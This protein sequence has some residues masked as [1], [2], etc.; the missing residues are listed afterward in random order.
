ML[1]AATG[2]NCSTKAKLDFLVRKS[3]KILIAK[4]WTLWVEGSTYVVFL[5]RIRFP[6]P[7]FIGNTVRQRVLNSIGGQFS[8]SNNFPKRFFPNTFFPKN[9]VNSFLRN[10]C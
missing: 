3:N 5:V 4:R 2:R 10:I 1:G 8:Q 9:L 6:L 7:K